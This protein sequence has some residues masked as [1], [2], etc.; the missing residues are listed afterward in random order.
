MVDTDAPLATKVGV[1]VLAAGGNAIDAAVA[2]AFALA[3]VYPQA[4]N[5]GGGGFA[6][7]RAA[8][9]SFH[10]LDFRET[11]PG[12][13]SKDMFLDAEGKPKKLLDSKKQVV[14]AGGR[15]LDA[16]KAG[17]LAAGVPGSVA[18]LFELHKKL[19]SK[20]WKDVVAPAIKLAKDGFIVD[21][22]LAKSIGETHG[23][24]EQF[25]ASKALFYPNGKALA[26]GDTWKSA[27]LAATLQ[28]IA[29]KGPD[30]FYKG[31][32]ADLIV[33][34]MKRGGG[35]ISKKDLESYTPKWRTPI[36]ASY[37]GT[38]LVSMPPP[39]SGGVVLAMIANLLEPYALKD[40]GWHS[41][42]HIHLEA[43]AMRRAFA[44]RNS[45]LGD[46]DFVKVPL[47][48]LLSKEYAKERGASITD[49]ATPS[50]DLK[51]GLPIPDGD[52]TTHFA[53]ADGNGAAVALTTTINDLYG[54]GETVEGAGFLLN[55]EMD[56]FTV[57]VGEPNMFGLVQGEANTIV[58]GKRMLSSMSPTIVLDA[59][60]KVLMVAGAR[61]GSRIITATWQVISNVVDFGMP[62]GAAVAAP[63][64]HQQHL[65]DD[66]FYERDGLPAADLLALGALGYV[67]MPVPAI[68]N[69]PAILRTP[70]G[71]S[72]AP[73]PRRGGAAAGL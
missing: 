45:L 52:H 28:R 22:Q 69:A 41:V 9:G 14:T 73:D 19:G 21:E 29:D 32:T 38:T 68:A 34:Q 17:A 16:S 61:G 58:P 13:A 30:G 51:A 20:P 25:A 53:V 66:L 71:W 33:A 48:K 7:V 50:S 36:R 59:D 27:A 67:M 39:S 42:E 35:L 65:P 5:L 60:G 37:R 56:D 44:D 23:V 63:R 47:E 10:A 8:D 26:K 57:K 62:I 12:A 55:D 3:V 72:G 64:V 46:P 40:K 6:V 18:G 1:D 70:S 54:A 31:K 15:A 49:R 2:T 43:E 24:L 4:G 11:A